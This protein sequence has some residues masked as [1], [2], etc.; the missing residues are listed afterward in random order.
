MKVKICMGARCT[1]MGA[2]AIYDAVENIKEWTGEEYPLDS[3][4]N[5]EVELVNC[6]DYCKKEST[7]V[8]PVVVIDEDVIFRATAQE[9]SEMIINELTGNSD[10]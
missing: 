4:E 6:L 3:L 2:N 9:V 10:S 5:L 7:A 1:M 8:A